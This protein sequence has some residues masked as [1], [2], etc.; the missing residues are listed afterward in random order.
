[1][2]TLFDQAASEYDRSFTHMCVGKAQR[3][4]VW[5]YLDRDVD[6]S[7]QHVL[8]INCG[9]GVDANEWH[10][11][12][13]K[14]IA[15]DLSEAMIEEAKRKYPNILFQKLDINDLGQIPSKY[16]LI[17]SN[18]GGLNCLN[19]QELSNFFRNATDKLEDN[20]KLA[21]VI[22]GKK[23]FW[24]RLYLVLKG[25]MKE[26]NRRNTS[27]AVPIAVSGTTVST[28]Y[29]SP[30]EIIKMAGAEFECIASH[31]I[32]LFVPPSYLAPFFERRKRSF[33]VLRFFDRIFTN[34]RWSNYADHYLIVLF[35]RK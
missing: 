12:G 23:T 10:K 20:G 13:K 2:S 35:K 8:E 11:R 33:G 5:K 24:D 1:M 17:F 21:L 26:R 31:P 14:I 22:M 19:D 7:V 32:G 4:Q 29:Y 3:E 34:K 30:L 18:F 28:W 6:Y 16:D 25:K 27:E 15:T 9:T